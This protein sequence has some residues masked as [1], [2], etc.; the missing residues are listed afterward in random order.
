[1]SVAAKNHV[2]SRAPPAGSV[3]S[4]RS[5]RTAAT[6]AEED[7]VETERRKSLASIKAPTVVPS[8]SISQAGDRLESHRSGRQS[9]RA[10]QAGGSHAASQK[11]TAEALE[12]L[13]ERSSNTGSHATATHK[14]EVIEEEEASRK[15]S[16]R[17]RAASKS[18][19]SSHPGTQSA[20]PETVY[21][22]HASRNPPPAR[23]RATSKAGTQASAKHSSATA[24][25]LFYRGERYLAWLQQHLHFMQGCSSAP[26]ML[27]VYLHL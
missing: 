20:R 16:T 23:S 21:S 8:D 12:A 26:S 10:S 6:R 15:P 9:T 14:V 18:L 4:A 7:D 13:S 24:Y 5:R 2:P 22:T 19:R 3:A 11:L 27:Q 1:M 25:F 17:S